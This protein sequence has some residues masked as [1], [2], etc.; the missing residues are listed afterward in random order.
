[1]SHYK[2]LKHRKSLGCYITR[3]RFYWFH[4][5][6]ILGYLTILFNKRSFKKVLKSRCGLKIVIAIK[7]PNYSILQRMLLIWLKKVWLWTELI[8]TI[9]I[10][11]ITSL[12][13]MGKK[14]K[15]PYLGHRFFKNFYKILLKY[16]RRSIW[17][18]Q[19][20]LYFLIGL[21]RDA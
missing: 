6:C 7:Y 3:A 9:K 21:I 18:I 12:S 15:H 14:G 10:Y 8:K 20:P 13:T 17:N 11:Q 16:R 4:V 2:F 5:T 19:C 1:M